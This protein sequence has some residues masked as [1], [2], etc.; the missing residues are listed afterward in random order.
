MSTPV[1]VAA[2]SA[3]FVA[4]AAYFY[5]KNKELEKRIEKLEADVVVLA[6]F[7]HTFQV[8]VATKFNQM[9]FNGTPPPQPKQQE[10]KVKFQEDEE[11]EQSESPP[12]QRRRRTRSSRKKPE[13][14]PEPEQDSEEE[15]QSESP[16]IVRRGKEKPKDEPP[17]KPSGSVM[18]EKRAKIQA[19][20]EQMK[21]SREASLEDGS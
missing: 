6:K 17:A 19:I 13:P 7:A 8:G 18:D 5:S 9:T 21:R 16:P 15:E 4:M 3:I 14:E 1:H 11:E 12:P 10:K 20:A 2:E